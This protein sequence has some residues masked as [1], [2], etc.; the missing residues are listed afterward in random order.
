VTEVKRD[1]K[2]RITAYYVT[3][4]GWIDKHAALEMV[5]N[6]EIDNGR[7]V[8]PGSGDPYI[9]TRRDEELFNNLSVLG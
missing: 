6:G 1:K 7:P 5:C 3:G 9:R 2:K 8:F 4:A